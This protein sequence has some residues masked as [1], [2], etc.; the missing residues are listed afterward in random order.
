ML[1]LGQ[2]TTTERHKPSDLRALLGQVALSSGC[3]SNQYTRIP[4]KPGSADLVVQA[5][6]VKAQSGDK[7]TR[8]K[9]GCWL[10]ASADPNFMKKA[11]RH[12][13]QAASGGGGPLWVYTVSLAAGAAGGAI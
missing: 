8:Y 10:K 4:L 13:R 2:N 7:R 1:I 12:C 5:L 9:L 3:A 6:A 11:I